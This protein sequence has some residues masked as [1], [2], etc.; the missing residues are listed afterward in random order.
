MRLCNLLRDERLS[1]GVKTRHGVLDVEAAARA[2]AVAAP[3]ATDEVV[4][5]NHLPSLRAL[6]ARC[7]QD[8]SFH[9]REEDV[10]FGPCIASPQKILMMGMNYRQHCAEIGQTDTQTPVFFN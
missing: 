8:G 1:L 4:R 2:H 6:V 10:T 3:A 7:D 9:L 5:G